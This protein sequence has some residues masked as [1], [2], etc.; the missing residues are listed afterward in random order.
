[1]MIDKY[2]SLSQDHETD[3]V[4][5]NLAHA[6]WNV[7]QVI[8]QIQ[9]PKKDL[10]FSVSEAKTD[11]TSIEKLTLKPSEVAEM[12]S[13]SRNSIYELVRTKQIPSI[14]FGK[15]IRIPRRA[16]EH[17]IFENQSAQI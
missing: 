3:R 1:M 10:L 9:A 14:R 4:I 12:L 11:D 17:W 6:I 8:Q 16:L 7:I 13:I 15:N 5:L 2:S